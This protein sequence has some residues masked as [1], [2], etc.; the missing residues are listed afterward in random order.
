MPDTPYQLAQKFRAQLLQREQ[1]AALQMQAVYKLVQDQL[2]RDINALLQEMKQRNDAGKPITPVALLRLARYRSL[3][4]AAD[5]ELSRFGA[6]A[7]EVLRSAQSEALEMALDATKQIL[8]SQNPTSTFSGLPTRAIEVSRAMTSDTSPVRNIFRELVTDQKIQFTNTLIKATA[9]GWH[10]NKTA[11]VMRDTLNTPLARSLTVSR[12]ETLRAYREA[13]RMASKEAGVMAW[14]WTA[15]KSVRTCL[16]CLALDGRLFDVDKPFPAHPNCRCVMIMFAP[17]MPFPAIESGSDWFE[18]Q[19]DEVKRQMMSKVAFEAYQ[20]GEIALQ[21]FVGVKRSKVWGEMRYERSYNDIL[22]AAQKRATKAG[23]FLGIP[24]NVT[25]KYGQGAEAFARELLGKRVADAELAALAGA[26]DGATVEV[27]AH[28]DGLFFNVKHPDI[29]F[30][31][32]RLSKDE[33]DRLYV[34]NLYFEKQ[35][36][37]QPLTGLRALLRQIEFGRQVGV[38]YLSA[39]AAGKPGKDKLNGFYTWARYGF[40]AELP[41]HRQRLLPND[42]SDIKTLNELMQRGGAQWWDTHGIGLEMTFDLSLNS[43]MIK[44]LLQYLEFLRKEKRWP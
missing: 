35:Q 21:D 26:L 38:R 42:M 18:R 28:T 27:S 36:W 5:Q 34:R 14:R 12:T 44:T 20:K 39:S 22:Q 10:P 3:Q 16:S 29:L 17:D 1:T 32:R 6:Q 31:Q 9:L 7:G 15:S 24:Q 19:P 40:E 8:H 23:M 2:S 43:S 4:Q 25:V 41:E 30:Q 13:S 37:G 33:L 11:K